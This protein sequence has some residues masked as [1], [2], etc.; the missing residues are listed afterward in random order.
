MIIESLRLKNIKSYGEGPAN[1]GIEIY[2]LPGIN[3]IAGLNGHGKTTVIEAIGFALFYS[4]PAFEEDFNIATYFLRAGKRSGEIDVQFRHDGESYRIERGI[5]PQ[6][7]RRSKAIQVRDGS[8][9]AE[10]DI[11][12]GN[13]VCRLF[14]FKKQQQLSELFSK[15][16]GVRQGRLTWPFDS[17][18]GEAKRFFEP[19]LQVAIFR[20]C[21]DRLKPV[22]DEFEEGVHAQEKILATTNERLREREGARESVE[23]KRL[24]RAELERRTK[25]LMEAQDAARKLKEELEKREASI[26]E[27]ERQIEFAR[28]SSNLAKQHCETAGS[29]LKE[30]NAAGDFVARVAPAYQKYE[31]AEQRLQQNRLRQKAQ[32]FLEAERAETEKNRLTL[33]ERM[34]AARDQAEILHRQSALKKVSR[35]A[36]AQEMDRLERYLSGSFDPFQIVETRAVRLGKDISEIAHFMRGMERGSADRKE[37]LVK[38]KEF[39]TTLRSWKSTTIDSARQQEAVMD[40]LYQTIRQRAGEARSART[41]LKMQLKQIADGFCPFLK[42]QCRQFDPE[43][44]QDD[45]GKT[46]EQIESL[47][48]QEAAAKAKY[49]LARS[50]RERFDREAISIAAK[51]STMDALITRFVGSFQDLFPDAVR[52][53]FGRLLTELPELTP[54]AEPPPTPGVDSGTSMLE[55]AD[56]QSFIFRQKLERWFENAKLKAETLIAAAHEERRRRDM[57]GQNL[58]HLNAQIKEIDREI[59]DLTADASKQIEAAKGFDLEGRKLVQLIVD[60]D[61]KL[62]EYATL[63]AEITSLE[64]VQQMTRGDFQRYLGAKPLADQKSQR[65]AEL[66]AALERL[67]GAETR[68]KRNEAEYAHIREGFDPAALSAARASLEERNLDLVRES[69]QLTHVVSELQREEKRLEEWEAARAMQA[70]CIR[71]KARL[72]AS[73]DLTELARTVLRASAP[74]VAQHLCDRIALHAQQI[75]NRINRDPIELRW[76]AMPRYSLRVTPGDRRFAMLSGG[77]QTKL[78]LAMTLAM[79]QNFSDLGFCIFDEPTYGVDAESRERLAEAILKSEE[80]A[81]LEQLIVVSHDEVFNGIIEQSVVL[82]KRADLGTEVEQGTISS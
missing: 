21:Y 29:R 20:D 55:T 14:G 65:E 30:A 51:Q 36:I 74:A 45:L 37:T 31:E 66:N 62:T 9:C 39:E 26:K 17:T 38:I 43:K 54:F 50:D 32:K 69:T 34:N 23:E 77:E 8:I 46:E 56:R 10:G 58:V 80:A 25:A 79:I 4:E 59:S 82:K 41:A 57:E 70:Q 13:F 68:L 12:V 33:S 42:E 60:L 5:G 15:L 78:A 63:N 47:N 40:T 2:F 44:V 72:N 3:R 81:N 67:L 27:S 22:R 71:E 61:E 18:A 48:A 52:E 73:I 35:I 49:D 11:E 28:G 75:F 53:P 24:K 64:Q 76:E 7:L 16:I 1:S 6:S 19:L